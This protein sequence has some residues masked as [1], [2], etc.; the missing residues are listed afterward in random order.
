MEKYK[1][2]FFPTDPFRRLV[3]TRM[4]G[5]KALGKVS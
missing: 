4:I 1:D 5:L 2:W 3:V